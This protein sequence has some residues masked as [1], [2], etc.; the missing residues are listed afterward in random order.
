M[1]VGF[2]L[3]FGLFFCRICRHEHASV[4]TLVLQGISCSCR[5]TVLLLFGWVGCRTQLF[6]RCID[7]HKAVFNDKAQRK[8]LTDPRDVFQAQVSHYFCPA[9]G[10]VTSAP[11]CCYREKWPREGAK[12][13]ELLLKGE[14]VNRFMLTLCRM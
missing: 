12:M 3:G 2:F 8:S 6:L 9:L 4:D 7:L 14:T 5:T 11:V 10:R 13:L 1:V